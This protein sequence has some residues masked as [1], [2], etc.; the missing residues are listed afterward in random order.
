VSAGILLVKSL[1]GTPLQGR[2]KPA[3]G[4]QGYG[5]L[6]LATSEYIEPSNGVVQTQVSVRAER[7]QV[8]FA[9]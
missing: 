2:T 7:L 4:G 5:Y 9:A 6:L 3:R 1:A 8:Q